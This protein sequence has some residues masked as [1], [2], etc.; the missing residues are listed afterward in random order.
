VR[1]FWQLLLSAL[2][3]LVR[4][5]A[6]RLSQRRDLLPFEDLRIAPA[7]TAPALRVAADEPLW[8]CG[9]HATLTTLVASA[10]AAQSPCIDVLVCAASLRNAVEAVANLRDALGATAAARLKHLE[11]KAIAIAQ[12]GLLQSCDALQWLQ[13]DVLAAD[14]AAPT[15][16][17]RLPASLRC[18]RI[19]A[20]TQDPVHYPVL[21]IAGRVKV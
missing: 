8:Q 18:L 20:R 12:L 10:G 1:S 5:T 13:A 2:P 9:L 6:L 21:D 11:V 17:L 7:A 4:L 14:D 3:S 16:A 19:A 15:T